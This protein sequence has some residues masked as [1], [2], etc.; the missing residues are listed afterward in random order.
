VKTVR[1]VGT[2]M[3]E[4]FEVKSHELIANP[5]GTYHKFVMPNGNEW[6][7]NDFG[8]RSVIIASSPEK[9]SPM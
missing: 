2:G 3:N 4:V 7:L 1:I 6:Y 8:L 9:L 5:A